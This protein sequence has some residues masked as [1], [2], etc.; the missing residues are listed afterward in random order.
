MEFLTRLEEKDESKM[1]KE[2]MAD[3][4]LMSEFNHYRM[5]K[6]IAFGKGI[7]LSIQASYGHYCTPRETTDLDDYSAMELGLLQNGEFVTVSSLLPEFSRLKEIEEYEDTVYGYV[8]VD[9]IGELY[10][11]LKKSYGLVK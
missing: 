10:Q 9:L 1:V 5:L 8:P 2:K 7:T 11:E 4:Q 6:G 3:I